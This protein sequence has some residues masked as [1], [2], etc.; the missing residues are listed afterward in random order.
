M[1]EI[2]TNSPV[3]DQKKKWDNFDIVE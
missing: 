3:D 2:V 1:D